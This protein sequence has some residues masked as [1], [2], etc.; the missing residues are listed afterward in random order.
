MVTAK[1][2]NDDLRKHK[3]LRL[4]KVCEKKRTFCLRDYVMKIESLIVAMKTFP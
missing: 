2:I 1:G 4:Y 3:I